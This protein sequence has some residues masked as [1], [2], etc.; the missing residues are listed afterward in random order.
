V[1]GH[2]VKPIYPPRPKGKLPPQEL[3]YYEST[4]RWVAQYK[5]NGSRNLIHV[6]E[7]GRVG[8]FSRHGSTH[9]KF[10]PTS[11]HVE[12]VL[13]LPGLVRGQ[14]YWLD[15]ELLNKTVTEVT[16]DK[17]VLFDVLQVGRYFYQHPAQMERLEI[18]AGI[19]G[20]PSVP[21]PNRGIALKVTDDLWMAET[22]DKD[23][24]TLFRRDLGPEV[25]GLLLRLKD[26][27]LEVFGQQEYETHMMLRCRHTHKNYPY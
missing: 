27:V 11:R 25:E 3:S 7:E 15:S 1:E 4:G 6:D 19:C 22:F 9:V 14:A 26:F 12:Q 10:V 23:F 24:L 5:Y 21:E 18:L 17:I 16:K 20:Y 8:F 2:L 13:A